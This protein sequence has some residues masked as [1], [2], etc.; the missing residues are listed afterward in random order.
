MYLQPRCLTVGD[1]LHVLRP[2]R[3]QRRPWLRRRWLRYLWAKRESVPL[4]NRGRHGGSRVL[5]AV[6]MLV[7][8][9]VDILAGHV[10]E[11]QLTDRARVVVGRSAVKHACVPQHDVA[12]PSHKTQPVETHRGGLHPLRARRRL[13]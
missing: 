7:R 2:L 13:G 10:V 4:A 5:F 8:D 12:P 11:Q 1:T 9:L 6:V 3:P